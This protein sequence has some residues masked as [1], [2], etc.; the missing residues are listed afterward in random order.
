MEQFLTS[1]DQHRCVVVC[2][3]RM[4]KVESYR[5]GSVRWSGDLASLGA[6]IY[7]GISG[8]A[9]YPGSRRFFNSKW[10][11]EGKG[12]C[13]FTERWLLGGDDASWQA[14]WAREGQRAETAQYVI[15][16]SEGSRAFSA[17]S[18]DS[19]RLGG[20]PD[21]RASAVSRAWTWACVAVGTLALCVVW[22]CLILVL[23]RA[24]ADKSAHQSPK[25][26]FSQNKPQR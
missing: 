19:C 12:G 7:H 22:S 8:Q 11:N 21:D 4:T 17:V 20:D 9:K 16:P 6:C 23:G 10:T 1:D 14:K 3:C 5:D 26:K 15:C 18:A 2:A 24:D 25:Q 13:V